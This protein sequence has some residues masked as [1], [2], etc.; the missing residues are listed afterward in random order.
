MMEDNLVN[1]DNIEKFL[2][3]CYINKIFYLNS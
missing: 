3:I 1:S 2:S